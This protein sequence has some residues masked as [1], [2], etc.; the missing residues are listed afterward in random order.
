MG[1]YTQFK[2]S[3]KLRY[4]TPEVVISMINKIVNN[5]DI[6]LPEGTVLYSA[7]QEIPPEKIDHEFFK[8]TRWASLFLSV[9]DHEG[10]PNSFKKINNTWTLQLHSDF[11]NYDSEIEQFINWISPYIKVR[12]KKIYIGWS[13]G[14]DWESQQIHYWKENP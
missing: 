1:Y 8:C 2:V 13:K 7:G 11:K 12:K 10:P 6:G 9:Y 5:C 3:I 4:D 14:E